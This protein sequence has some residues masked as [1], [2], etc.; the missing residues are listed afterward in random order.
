L[1]HEI[2]WKTLDV[3]VYSLNK[4]TRLNATELGKITV[5]H[6]FVFANKVNLPLH[7]FA[8]D[9][10]ELFMVMFV[11]HENI[12]L[13]TEKPTIRSYFV[14]VPSRPRLALFE[15]AV[16]NLKLQWTSGASGR[17]E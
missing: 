3:A 1:K 14:N 12:S 15:I 17:L 9:R 6:H 5:E 7:D 2:G 10:C 16:C 13:I 8:G 4:H 11:G